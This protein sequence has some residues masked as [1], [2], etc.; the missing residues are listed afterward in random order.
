MILLLVGITYLADGFATVK[1]PS[2]YTREI[3]ALCRDDE[4]FGFFPSSIPDGAEDVEFMCS[5]KFLVGYSRVYVSYRMPKEYIADIEELYGDSVS[6]LECK[7][8]TVT[9]DTKIDGGAIDLFKDYVGKPHCDVYVGG[10]KNRYGYA[11]NRETNE[12]CF[13]YDIVVD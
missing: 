3:N 2:R 9:E 4:N 7:D 12:I 13:F 11:I 8:V 5:R 6:S 10:Y 1:S